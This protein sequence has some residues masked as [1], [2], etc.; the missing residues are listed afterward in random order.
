MQKKDKKVLTE[1]VNYFRKELVGQINLAK[2]IK[3]KSSETRHKLNI[4]I[5]KLNNILPLI[6]PL[7][8]WI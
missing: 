5:T 6:Q 3:V 1:E 8:P 2:K 7:Q 4:E